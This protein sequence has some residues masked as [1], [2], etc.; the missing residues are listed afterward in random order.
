MKTHLE[1]KFIRCGR[2]GLPMFFNEEF[3]LLPYSYDKNVACIDHAKS[4]IFTI[5]DRATKKEAGEL[6]LRIGE[7]AG[8]FY[9]GHIG[10][11]I[12]PPYRGKNGAYQACRL[13]LPL[14]LDMNLRT[15]VITTDDDNI[16]SI[17]TCEKLGCKLECTVDVPR[18][19]QRKYEISARK[20][21]Y[22]W[23]LS[24]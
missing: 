11:H 12:D 23:F 9:L 4:M 19:I 6:A 13:A 24:E 20:R 5:I 8:M 3:A 1:R 10:Y 7:S 21:R 22:I 18:H 2:A 16:P 17:R 15:L 14:L